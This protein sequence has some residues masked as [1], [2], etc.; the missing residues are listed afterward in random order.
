MVCLL[1]MDTLRLHHSSNNRIFSV[2]Q[3]GQQ[4]RSNPQIFGKIGQSLE[5][6]IIE[7]LKLTP[8]WLQRLSRFLRHRQVWECRP[9][10]ANCRKGSG[11]D[12]LIRGP[13]IASIC[14]EL[15]RKYWEMKH[16][17]DARRADG[18]GDALKGIWEGEWLE[19]VWRCYQSFAT[20]WKSRCERP[21]GGIFALRIVN[22]VCTTRLPPYVGPW[23]EM[24]LW[25]W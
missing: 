23:V 13:F 7:A 21:Q 12:L 15:W 3:V 5:N 10:D 17:V 19:L 18:P 20:R 22:R 11:M 6:R 9:G 2:P 25:L 1:A 24:S 16:H 4:E 14:P 8:V